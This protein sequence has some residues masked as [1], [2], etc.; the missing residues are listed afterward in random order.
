MEIQ[1][2]DNETLTAYFK[3]VEL[4]VV[5]LTQVAGLVLLHIVC[6]PGYP[7]IS[8]AVIRR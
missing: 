1:Q 7:S 3:F 6:Y 2:K 8:G 4:V 5:Y